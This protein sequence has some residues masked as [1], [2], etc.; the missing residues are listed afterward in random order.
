MT[1]GQ[2]IKH[3]RELRGMTQG[4][5]AKAVGYKT[6]SSI[7][8]IE[9]DESDLPQRKI[10]LIANALEVAPAELLDDTG[11]ALL[12]RESIDSL[13]LQEQQILKMFRSMTDEGKEYVFKTLLMASEAYGKKDHSIPDMENRA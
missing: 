6:R 4:D 8:K 12:G 2:K 1:I 3:F 9:N 7:N 10:A 13:S 11:P 5:L